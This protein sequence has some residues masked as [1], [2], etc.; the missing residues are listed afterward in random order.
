MALASA[1]LLAVLSQHASASL[2]AIDFGSEFVKVCLIKPGRTPIAVVVNEMSRRKTPALVGVLSKDR[3]I[4]EEAFSFAVRYPDTIFQRARDLLGKPADDPTLARML[5][6]HYLPHET[7]WHPSRRVAAY[8]LGENSSIGAE[9]LVVCTDLPACLRHLPVPVSELHLMP[10][11]CTLLCLDR[12]VSSTMP[13][14]LQRP[15]PV[16]LSWMPSSPSPPSSARPSGR[17]S[18]TRPRSQA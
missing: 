1:L 13:G 16:A 8:K 12:P 10:V 17:R 14:A 4:G 7:V 5:K 11:L 2:M 3:L 18:W 6:D 9:E 15:K